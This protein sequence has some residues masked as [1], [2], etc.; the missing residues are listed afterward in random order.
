MVSRGREVAANNDIGLPSFDTNL[1]NFIRARQERNKTIHQTQNPFIDDPT[2]V[3][4]SHLYTV[5]D[6]GVGDVQTA[7][8]GYVNALNDIVNEDQ[9]EYRTKSSASRAIEDFMH[10]NK[11]IKLGNFGLSSSEP[12]EASPSGGAATF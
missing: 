11:K 5:P 9:V 3:G 10:Y 7:H 2:T 1:G 4:A 12:S 6:N 8:V